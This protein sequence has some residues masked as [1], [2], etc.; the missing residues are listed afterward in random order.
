M[1]QIMDNWWVRLANYGQLVGQALTAGGS[2]MF[3]HPHPHVTQTCFCWKGVSNFL[4]WRFSSLNLLIIVF[5]LP[6]GALIFA[7]QEDQQL[8]QAVARNIPTPRK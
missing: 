5:Y 8:S 3:A 2:G 4:W 7:P 6:T 1:S